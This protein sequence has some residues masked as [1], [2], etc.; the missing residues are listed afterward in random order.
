[1]HAS[2]VLNLDCKRFQRSGA[3]K[4]AS[5]STDTST[6]PRAGAVGPACLRSRP[7]STWLIHSIGRRPRPIS[8]SVPT[9]LRTMWR[10]K[11]LP[12]ISYTI[13]DEDNEHK[14]YEG[15]GGDEDGGDAGEGSDAGDGRETGGAAITRDENT[16]RSVE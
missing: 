11:P 4:P 5:Y 14:G 6:N 2:F 3:S 12:E 10:R 7:A 13:N 15:P 1:M 16:W 8:T 9:T